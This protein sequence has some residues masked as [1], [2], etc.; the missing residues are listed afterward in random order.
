MLEKKKRA[1]S[2]GIEQKFWV[3]LEGKDFL[4][5]KDNKRYLGFAE[6]FYSYL[7]KVLDFNN[8]NVYPAKDGLVSKGV[9]VESYIT[10]DVIITYSF[11]DF[12]EIDTFNELKAI[13]KIYNV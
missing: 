10:K 12:I 9:I 8:V 3:E 6:L 1:E 5:K 11:D 7:G 2:H 4:Y 13:D